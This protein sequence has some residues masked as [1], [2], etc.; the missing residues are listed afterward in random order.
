MTDFPWRIYTKNEIENDFLKIKNKL[1]NE[2][3]EFPI[4]SSFLGYKCTDLFFQYERLNTCS[5]TNVSC[6]EY[7]N[8]R[9]DK[10]IEY[11]SLQ[12][13]KKDLFGT[14]VFMKRAPSHF[15]PYAAGIVYKHFNAKKV[16][17]PYAG[18]GDRC[19]A[20]IA[21][22]IDYVGVDSND[23]LKVPFKKLIS[24]FKHSSNIKFISDKSENVIGSLKY[25][26]DLI[27]TSPPFWNNNRIVEK[28]NN[29]EVDKEIFLNNSLF[30]IFDKY[31]KK[32]TIAIYINEF[33]Y[34]EIKNKFGECNLI[35]PF[36]S[37]TV[38]KNKNKTV[39]NIYCFLKDNN[40]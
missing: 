13:A 15:S 11:H 8:S 23:K 6:I 5:D 32:V 28:Y 33:M 17:D 27:F 10:I 4:K 18:W 19:L 40:G 2:N 21:L 16:F 9:K 39:H 26:P 34:T 31:F 25:N 1:E 12:K 35:L 29:C 36:K 38:L 30:K 7:W 24:K 14:I 37:S 22:N 20:A 3:A